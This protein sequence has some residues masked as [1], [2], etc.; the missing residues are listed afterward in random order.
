MAVNEEAATESGLTPEQAEGLI[1]AGAEL[2][3]VRRAYE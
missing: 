3:D 1:D 2:I